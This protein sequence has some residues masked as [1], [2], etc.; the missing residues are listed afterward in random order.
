MYY[1]QQHEDEIIEKYFP[2]GYIGGCIDI[3]ATDGVN[4]NNT[5]HF[6]QLGWYCM[7][8]E[9]NP[10]FF[11]SL[12]NNRKNAVNLAVSDRNEDQVVFNIVSL[13]GSN[14]EAIS[15]LRIDERLLKD[16]SNFDV[17]IKEIV[18]DVRTLDYCLDYFYTYQQIDFVSVDTEGTEL[19][20]LK[21]FDI[22]KWQ[23]KLFIIENNYEDKNIEEYMNKFGYIK[24]QRI[25][26]NDFYIKK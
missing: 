10:N 11:N 9:P 8:I 7:C 15:S 24:D 18:C 2:E 21:G 16:H 26:V 23:P 22:N 4:I 5:L 20:V 12:K 6:E 13:N 19:D 25:S 1:G 14:E 3:G 17:N